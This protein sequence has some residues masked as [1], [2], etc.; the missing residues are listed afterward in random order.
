MAEPSS[1]GLL[2]HTWLAYVGRHSVQSLCNVVSLWMIRFG[3]FI[4][5]RAQAEDVVKDPRQ[6][7]SA[8]C[9]ELPWST[10]V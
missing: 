1:D 6:E 4:F 10:V 8:I 7:T 9:E 3:N 2:K 5:S